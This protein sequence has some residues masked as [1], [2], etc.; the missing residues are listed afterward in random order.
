MVIGQFGS[1]L[2]VLVDPYTQAASGAIRIVINSYWD[3]AFRR[4]DSFA[5][6]EGIT[7]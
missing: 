1:A 4:G 3:T 5:T 2:D 6:I 7:F